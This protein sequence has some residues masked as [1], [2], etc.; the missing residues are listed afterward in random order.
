M[1]RIEP[2]SIKKNDSPYVLKGK[3][4]AKQYVISGFGTMPVRADWKP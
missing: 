1:A 2:L 4:L 3:E